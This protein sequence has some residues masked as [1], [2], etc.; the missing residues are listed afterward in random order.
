M[1]PR[2][3]AIT[4]R[5][6]TGLSHEEQ[7]RLLAAGGVQLVQLREKT[8]SPRDF[9]QAAQGAVRLARELGLQVII[10]DRV[11]IALALDADGVHLGQEDISPEK[12]RSLLGAG[13]TVGFS[14]HSL[15]Q[16]KAADQ[17][18]V[19]YIA[20]GPIFPTSTKPHHEPVVGLELIRTVRQVVNKPVV[21]IGGI[22]LKTGPAVIRAGAESIAV[23]AGLL[24][25]DDIAQRAR[26]FLERL[27]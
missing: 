19:D 10:N 18:P 14:T 8:A 25:T 9:Y 2:L 26:E 12:A 22:T 13:K 17:L 5:N 1:L 21:A 24:K 11:D 23:V 4:D 27:E 15:E 6:V 3:Y 16:A 20:I 7:V